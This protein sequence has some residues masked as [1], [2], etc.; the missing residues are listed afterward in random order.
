MSN[1]QFPDDD[2]SAMMPPDIEKIFGKNTL[3]SEESIM[4]SMYY[5]PKGTIDD[6]PVMEWLTIHSQEQRDKHTG[7][8]LTLN[9]GIWDNVNNKRVDPLS[10]EGKIIVD[11]YLKNK[12]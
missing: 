12:K 11:E 5:I 7:D 2:Q 6:K 9:I 10:E 8:L 1:E 3:F 4:K